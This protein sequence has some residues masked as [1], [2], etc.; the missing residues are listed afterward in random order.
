[1]SDFQDNLPLDG[2]VRIDG[3]D[4]V[5]IYRGYHVADVNRCAAESASGGCAAWFD[6][7]LISPVKG[8]D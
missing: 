5:F 8:E 7:S 6:R 3:H 4:G 1:M 2:R